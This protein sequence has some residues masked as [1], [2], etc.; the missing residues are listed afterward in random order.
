MK[1]WL[2]YEDDYG[3]T[4]SPYWLTRVFDDEAKLDEYTKTLPPFLYMI[5]EVEH[6]GTLNPEAYKKSIGGMFSDD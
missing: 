6:L 1:V 2:V 5:R 4:F 3:G